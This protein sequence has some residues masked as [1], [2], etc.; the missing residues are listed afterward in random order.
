[1]DRIGIQ[2]EAFVFGQT[3]VPPRTWKRAVNDVCHPLHHTC[4]ARLRGQLGN[5]ENLADFD[6][7]YRLDER[8]PINAGVFAS[9]RFALQ[10]DHFRELYEREAEFYRRELGKAFTWDSHDLF[11]GDQGRLN[12]L[13]WKQKVP[14]FDLY[15]EGHYLWG[16]RGAVRL[17]QVLA[18]RA[19]FTFIHWAGCPRPSPS[20]FSETPLL[21]LLASTYAG[22]PEDYGRL[23]EVP[24]LRVWERFSYDGRQG[25]SALGTPW[26]TLRDGKRLVLHYGRVLLRPVKRCVKGTW[27]SSGAIS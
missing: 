27:R 18:A 6:P 13:I 9:A 23:D 5:I 10:E 1:M 21:R 15:P 24:A 4:M 17:E 22:L 14:L 2:R 7:A 25:A 11:F 16:G 26:W 19:R 12:Y 20:K 8:Y 3:A